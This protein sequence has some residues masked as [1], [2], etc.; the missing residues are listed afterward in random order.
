MPTKN[1][2]KIYV[3][4]GIYH[5]YN[6]GVEK[7]KIFMDGQDY[8]VFL[9]YLKSYLTSPEEQAKPP[10]NLRYFRGAGKGEGGYDLHDNIKLLC[11]CLMPN[12]FHLLV[13]Q[14]TADAM[15]EL[16]RRL[17]NAYVRYFNER[18]GR[19]GPL[20][21]G[22]YKAVLADSE[23]YFLHLS[24][25]IHRNP[26]ELSRFGSGKLGEY[27]YSSYGEYLGKRTTP[28]ISTDEIMTYF[29]NK[30]GGTPSGFFNYGNFV[31]NNPDD[32]GDVLGGLALDADD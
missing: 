4:N 28:W 20:F 9:Y 7:R 27:P 21:Q 15:V 26:L 3:E 16:M 5:I 22:R 13:K 6:R 17:G 8:K 2:L 32:S 24:R 1:A 29:E 14:Q 25:Y 30:T 10:C 23:T 12:H 18:Q 31:E 19:Q 11:Y